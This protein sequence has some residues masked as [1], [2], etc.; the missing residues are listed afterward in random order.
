MCVA[1]ITHKP[2]T[3]FC[4]CM[5][6]QSTILIFSVKI[7]RMDPIR[8]SMVDLSNVNRPLTSNYEKDSPCTSANKAV[9][10]I[11]SLAKLKDRAGTF[12]AK[13]PELAQ[14]LADFHATMP[15]PTPSGILK[16]LRICSDVH[17]SNHQRKEG[18]EKSQ[19]SST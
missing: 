12:L 5:H 2:H 9:K 3:R 14:A 7:T 19:N 18:P 11:K 1:F 8:I 15:V 6:A 16:V 10:F 13:R 4:S 17:N